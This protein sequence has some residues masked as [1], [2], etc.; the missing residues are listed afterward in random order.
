MLVLHGAWLPARGGQP[1]QF[2]VWAEAALPARRRGRR[3]VAP[4]HQPPPH[5]FAAPARQ[6]QTA[7][8]PLPGG[9]GPRE[10]GRRVLA[11]LPTAGGAPQ[12]S[13]E[14]AVDRAA[15]PGAPPTLETWQV[16]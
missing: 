2:A 7:L 15:A 12:A 3:A 5:P 13:P 16:E 4:A 1:A 8:A 6:L 11:R 9:A 10:T 14:L